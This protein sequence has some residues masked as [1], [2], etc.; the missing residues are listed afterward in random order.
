MLVTVYDVFMMCY[1]LLHSSCRIVQSDN[2]LSHSIIKVESIPTK[3][4]LRQSAE[5]PHGSPLH[6]RHQVVQLYKYLWDKDVHMALTH[7]L[8]MDVARPT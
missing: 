6:G 8:I 1:G 3:L 5:G 7:S 2:D 4:I